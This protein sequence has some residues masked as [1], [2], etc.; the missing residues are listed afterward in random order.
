MK[1]LL[2]SEEG[3]AKAVAESMNHYFKDVNVEAITFDYKNH[4][5]SVEKLEQTI[6]EN[7]NEQILILVDVYGS[8]AYVEARVALEKFGI[9]EKNSLVI[10]G[11]SVPMAVKLYNFKEMVSIEYIRMVY[12]RNDRLGYNLPIRKIA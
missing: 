10:C 7:A 4:Q 1:M 2:L 3:V 12:E 8:V 11:L 6:A 9:N 5:K